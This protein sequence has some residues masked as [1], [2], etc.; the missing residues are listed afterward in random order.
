MR[1]GG[2]GVSQALQLMPDGAVVGWEF[3]DPRG[4]LPEQIRANRQVRSSSSSSV[5]LHNPSV[6]AAAVWHPALSI[7]DL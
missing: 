7:S 5:R 3:D 6:A 1:V 2:D 4:H